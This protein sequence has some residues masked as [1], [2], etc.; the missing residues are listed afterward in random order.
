MLSLIGHN[1]GRILIELQRLGLDE[2]TIVIYSA[3]HGDW[4]GD[5]GLLLKGPM[6]YEGLLRVGCIVRGPGVPAGKVVADPVSTLDI[7]ATLLD[8]GDAAPL[9]NI[10]SRSLRPLIEGDGH[11]DF[12]LS[13]WDLRPSRTGTRL[14][15]RAVRTEAHKLTVDMITKAGELYDLTADPYEMDN[16]FDDPAALEIREKLLTFLDQR[17]SDALEEQYE[18]VGMA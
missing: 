10:H 16:L 8:Y 4:L 11:R 2:N 13:E 1:V 6:L 18:Q 17:P 14:E 3:D 15:L 9:G 7:A 5:H 12:A